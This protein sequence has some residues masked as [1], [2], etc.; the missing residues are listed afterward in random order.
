MACGIG[1][2]CSLC[3]TIFSLWGVITL[4]LV[5][6]GFQTDYRYIDNW[7]VSNHQQAAIASYIAA[8]LYGAFIIGC[9]S[10]AFQLRFTRAKGDKFDFDASD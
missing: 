10:R 6:I 3:C 8:A 7:N 1:P 4:V 5:G 2:K 9:G